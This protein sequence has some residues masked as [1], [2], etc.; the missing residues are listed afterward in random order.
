[1]GRERRQSQDK[2]GGERGPKPQRSSSID[3]FSKV[4]SMAL[5][6]SQ[7]VGQK[8]VRGFLSSLSNPSSDSGGGAGHVTP[9]PVVYRND[10]LASPVSSVEEG[11][12]AMSPLS[13]ESDGIVME[14]LPSLN[15]VHPQTQLFCDVTMETRFATVCVC[16]FV[17]ISSRT[18][19]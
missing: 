18:S 19:R 5:Q 3:I 13:N 7:T 2:G 9:Q 1:M 11:R 10:D 15:Q 6:G 17:C 8:V 4:K 12:F 16:V 14:T